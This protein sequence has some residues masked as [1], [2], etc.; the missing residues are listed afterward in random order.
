[1]ARQGLQRRAA[2]TGQA[3]LA[4]ILPQLDPPRQAM[5]DAA[6]QLHYRAAYSAQG[7]NDA[8]QARL[9]QLLRALEEEMR[10]L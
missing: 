7:L 4:R 8:E 1:M 9:T 2:E 3:W 6:M 5:L 10:R